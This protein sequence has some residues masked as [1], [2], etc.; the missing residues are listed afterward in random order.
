MTPAN[1]NLVLALPKG[2]ILK[3]LMP[4][5]KAADIVPEPAFED[6]DLD[7][8]RDALAETG[9]AVS[10]VNAKLFASDPLSVTDDSAFLDGLAPG[11]TATAELAPISEKSSVPSA[12]WSTRSTDRWSP[13][14]TWPSRRGTACSRAAAMAS[15][16]GSST[17]SYSPV[18]APDGAAP[19]PKP[20][21]SVWTSAS[22]VGLPR[23]SSTCRNRTSVTSVTTTSPA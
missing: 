4:L 16:A 12:S 17:A 10:N 5:L 8:L 22:T 20:P 9:L 6:E 7:A 15:F 18:L 13:A 21:D 2:R 19:R 23:E 11:E 1:E 3:E 14:Y